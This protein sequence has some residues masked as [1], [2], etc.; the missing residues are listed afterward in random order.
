[1]CCA[2]NLGIH[3]SNGEYILFIDSDDYFE[4]GIFEKLYDVILNYKP[5]LIDFGIYY[6]N[7]G[8]VYP[9][10]NQSITKDT[11]LGRKFIENKI[12]P[13]L[14]NLTN[15]DYFIDNYCCNKVFRKTIITSHN[16]LFDIKR[17]KWEDRPFLAN[18][19]LYIK[20][21]YSMSVFGYNYVVDTP[22]S[23]S[24]KFDKN[25]LVYIISSYKEYK[26][27]YEDLSYIKKNHSFTSKYTV[28]YY[29]DLFIK[30]SLEYTKVPYVDFLTIMQKLRNE[31]NKELCILMD[32]YIPKSLFEKRY[33]SLLSNEKFRQ[34][35]YLI[36]FKTSIID[37]ISEIIKIIRLK[38]SN[39][40]AL[41]KS[42]AQKLYYNLKG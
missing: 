29:F 40:L 13:R 15:D 39:L 31:Y 32:Y 37:K 23:L 26:G 5:D 11:I 42:Y 24:K 21:Y 19:C 35:Y 33:I 14:V 16:I 2:R 3:S 1:M 8:C 4:D 27:L 18:F 34:L 36:I 10:I 41:L 28:G 7:N 25:T 22:N 17:K 38:L 30:T 6:N 12:I 20:S 9:S